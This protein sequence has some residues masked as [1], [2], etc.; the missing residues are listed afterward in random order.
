MHIEEFVGAADDI[1]LMVLQPE[2]LWQRL[3]GRGTFARQILDRLAAETAVE[4]LDLRTAAVIDP[5]DGVADRARA[6][7]DRDEAFALVRDADRG[8]AIRTHLRGQI[9][10]RRAERRPPILSILFVPIRVR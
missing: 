1:R 5:E 2:Q 4:R 10:Q 6:F 3:F 7:I 8:D 9:A